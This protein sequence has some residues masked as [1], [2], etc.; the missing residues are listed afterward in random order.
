VDESP[1]GEGVAT[2]TGFESCGGGSN[3]TAEALT[4]MR[5]GQVL[6]RNLRRWWR[7]GG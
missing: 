6:S 5:I 7:E 2:H 4:G 3:A 1:Y